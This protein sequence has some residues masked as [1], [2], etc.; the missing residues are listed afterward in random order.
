MVPRRGETERLLLRGWR[1][2]D[3]EPLREIYEQPA[4]LATAGEDARPE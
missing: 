1:D 2:E 3:V 4:F